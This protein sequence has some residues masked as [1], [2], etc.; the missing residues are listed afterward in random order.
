MASA[1]FQSI[2]FFNV[3]ALS[4]TLLVYVI[5]LFTVKSEHI[6]YNVI[7]ESDSMSKL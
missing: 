3:F 1:C 5:L 7:K 6:Q 4:M 2:I